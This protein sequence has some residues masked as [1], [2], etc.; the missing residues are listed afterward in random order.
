MCSANASVRDPDADSTNVERTKAALADAVRDHRRSVALLTVVTAVVV[1][2]IG[3]RLVVR[4][5]APHLSSA[6]GMFAETIAVTVVLAGAAL[7]LLWIG[8]PAPAPAPPKLVVVANHRHLRLVPTP[9]GHH[10]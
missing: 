5:V 7:W 8:A 9:G 1:A 4:L 6:G 3:T 2:Q 10:D